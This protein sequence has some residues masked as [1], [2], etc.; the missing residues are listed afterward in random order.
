MG[1]NSCYQHQFN[2]IQGICY[3]SPNENEIIIK[4]DKLDIIHS[5]EFNADKKY[6]KNS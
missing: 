3:N 5:D 1:N 4:E 2:D 6:S